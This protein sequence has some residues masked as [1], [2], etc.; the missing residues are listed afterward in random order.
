MGLNPIADSVQ[1]FMSGVVKPILDKIVPDAKDRLEASQKL[2]TEIYTLTAAQIEINKIEAASSSVFVAGW[3]P[4]I[5]WVC[6]AS[7]VYAL[8][9]NDF[10]NWSLEVIARLQ[11][12]PTP[13]KFPEP[14]TQITFQILMALLGLGTMRSW[15]KS[16]GVASK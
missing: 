9:G 2:E 1:G 3:R 6:G 10:F 13:P 12:A 4:F 5:G 14:D 16:K 11:G 15:E 8:V 7:L